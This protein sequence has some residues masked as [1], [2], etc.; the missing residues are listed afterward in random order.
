MIPLLCTVRNCRLPL[1]R[2]ER[3]MVC[4]NGHSFDIARSGYCN[5]LQ[6]QDRRS[7]SAG[8]SPE[9]V[10]ARHRFLDAGHE[11]RI[12]DT[13]IEIL[14]TLGP[15]DAVLDAGCGDGHHLGTIAKR[16]AIEGHG[17]DLSVPAIDLAARRYPQCHWIV[18]NADR[19]LPYGD[20]SFRVVLSITARM[21][22]PEFRRV[23]RGNGHLVVAIPAADDLAE[24]REAIHGEATARDRV[25]RTIAL[26]ADHFAFQ[27]CERAETR[28]LLDRD[29]I[30][31]ALTSS[32]RGMR[33]RE[34]QRLAQVDSVTVTLSRDILV[35]AP[36]RV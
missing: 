9:A 7:R 30:V 25:E 36:R 13:I 21:N 34:R 6:P 1:R 11:E 29:S 17:I 27:R 31:T 16:F 15:A 26:F 10:A 3:R 8:D 20:A 2:E 32:Y 28:A 33:N 14:A 5:L 22:A 23:I 4:P 18:A 12:L 19:F 24:L 35:F